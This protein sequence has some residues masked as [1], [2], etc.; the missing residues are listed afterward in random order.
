MV[1][2]LTVVKSLDSMLVDNIKIYPNYFYGI[3]KFC[4]LYTQE[5]N[6]ILCVKLSENQSHAQI[7]TYEIKN[8]DF[9][10]KGISCCSTTVLPEG[11]IFLTGGYSSFTNGTTNSLFEF[12]IETCK[13]IKLQPMINGRYHHG[14]CY[15]D[16]KI[17]VIG[18]RSI[19][20]KDES[21]NLSE[22]YDLNTKKWFPIFPTK[23]ACHHSAVCS[24]G[25]RFLYKFGGYNNLQPVN[26]IERYSIPKNRWEI[27]EVEGLKT[28]N[29]IA[30]AEALKINKDTIMIFGG[31]AN[32][33]NHP[34]MG[35]TL[36]FK[37]INYDENISEDELKYEITMNSKYQIGSPTF[38]TCPK[39]CV[40]HDFCLYALTNS[41]HLLK[42]DGISWQEL[43]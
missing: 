25:S 10:M 5:D 30:Q 12:N 3:N 19:G 22:Y 24:F 21:I 43:V 34:Y 27:L 26:T 18:G 39:R 35:I 38:F 14:T 11:R 4:C 42:F 31:A 17:Y 1:L 20:G 28:L 16:N 13:A 8:Y 7:N 37:T 2:T 36:F 33:R 23:V 40:I 41:H 29:F 32:L 15:L 9:V 6:K